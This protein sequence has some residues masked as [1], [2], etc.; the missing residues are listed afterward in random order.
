[1]PPPSPSADMAELI[2][3]TL[4]YIGSVTGSADLSPALFSPSSFGGP[5]PNHNYSPPA[6]HTAPE[7]HGEDDVITVQVTLSTPTS[8][9]FVRTRSDLSLRLEMSVLPS[10]ESAI[11]DLINSPVKQL[12]WYLS[13]VWG[14]SSKVT[15]LTTKR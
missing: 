2:R 7:Q 6:L 8:T 13:N 14:R 15:S 12:L 3:S 9:I 11:W 4:P 5:M 10:L 1:M